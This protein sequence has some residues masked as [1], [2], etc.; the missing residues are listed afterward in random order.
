M[1]LAN[2]VLVVVSYNAMVGS[3][4]IMGQTLIF[5]IQYLDLVIVIAIST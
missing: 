2:L 5:S 4:I 1:R 3:I